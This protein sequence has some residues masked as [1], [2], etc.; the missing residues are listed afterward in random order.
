MRIP[1]GISECQTIKLDQGLDGDRNGFK[2]WVWK[3]ASV[4]STISW[5]CIMQWIGFP[6][7]SKIHSYSHISQMIYDFYESIHYYSPSYNHF[8]FSFSPPY[9]IYYLCLGYVALLYITEIQSVC[10]QVAKFERSK[11]PR[12]ELEFPHCLPSRS[13]FLHFLSI[14]LPS[15]FSY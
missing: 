5:H 1:I 3:S 9:T 14:I 6:W 4:C 2:D 15:L 13:R 11:H 7:I 10:S 12:N 8:W